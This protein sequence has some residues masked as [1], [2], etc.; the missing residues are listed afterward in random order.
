MSYM[1]TT[2]EYEAYQYEGSFSLFG[3]QTG[4]ALKER[5]AHLGGLIGVGAPVEPCTLERNYIEPPPTTELAIAP[6]ATTPDVLAGTT[7]K[8]PADVQRFTGTSFSWIGGG[9]S[10]EWQQN[11]PMVELQRQ[12]GSTWQTVASDL[13]STVP[14]HYDKCGAESHWTAY[15]DPTVDATPGTYRFHVTGHSALAPGQVSPYTLDSATFTVSPYTYLTVVND[16]VGVYHVANPAPDPLANYRYRP[17]YDGTATV[18]GLGATF[19][20]PV[21][22]TRTIAPGEITDAYGNTN[23][24]TITVTDT[25]VQATPA[26]A[27]TPPTSPALVCAS[28]GQP[29][30]SVPET[31]WTPGF[32]LLGMVVVGVTMRRVRRTR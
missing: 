14:I 23:T 20:V 2:Q 9:P 27:A 11:D 6:Q 3:Q 15:T 12:S 7:E 25:G 16:G 21:G 30:A 26:R 31:P 17:R 18:A 19:T 24:Q 4:N 28:A 8:Q 1:A 32:V 29:N 22:Q 13:D 5:L 10:A